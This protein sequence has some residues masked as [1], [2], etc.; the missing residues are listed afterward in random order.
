MSVLSQVGNRWSAL[1]GGEKSAVAMAAL[2]V[3]AIGLAVGAVVDLTKREGA[4]EQL[5]T[6]P[7][8]VTTPNGID[9]AVRAV[10]GAPEGCQKLSAYRVLNDDGNLVAIAE[11]PIATRTVCPAKLT[12][13]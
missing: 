8:R 3:T 10:G 9:Y 5:I 11:T 1:D 4:V 6:A 7:G 12:N 13:G 2:A